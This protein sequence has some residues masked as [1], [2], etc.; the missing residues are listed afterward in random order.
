MPELN[1]HII[2]ADP[3][4]LEKYYETVLEE[5][6]DVDLSHEISQIS[7]LIASYRELVEIN[8]TDL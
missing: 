2:M 3:N 1:Y 6:E 8:K 5:E 4:L 7:N